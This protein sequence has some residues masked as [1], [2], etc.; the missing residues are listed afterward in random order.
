MTAIVCPRPACAEVA[1][2]GA[3]HCVNCGAALTVSALGSA[4]AARAA[5]LR[6]IADGRLVRGTCAHAT[7]GECFGQIEGHH[8]DYARQLD[9]V[10]L[11]R[12]HHRRLHAAVA[13]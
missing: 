7:D 4:G 11:C 3:T 12:T 9:V 13:A 1:E 6:A 2:H 5:V 8:E 10:W